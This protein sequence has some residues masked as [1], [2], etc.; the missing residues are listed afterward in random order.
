MLLQTILADSLTARRARDTPR[1]TLLTTLYSECAMV[2]KND[3]NRDTTDEEVIKVIRKFVKGIDES[4]AVTGAREDD[5]S[6]AA[7]DV[8]RMEKT[9]LDGY[10]PKTAS[11][12]DVEAVVRETVAGLA[13]K[14]PKAMGA[15]M[16]V[17]KDRFGATLDGQMASAVTKRV[18]A[19]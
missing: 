8:L 6:K 2:G 10:L 11:E 1:A 18:L 12:A 9:V 14:S 5:A 16:K 13:D 7:A 15:V 17:L 4:L 3:G 19:G